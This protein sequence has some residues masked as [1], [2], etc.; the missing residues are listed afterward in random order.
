LILAVWQIHKHC[1]TLKYVKR[2]ILFTDAESDTDW[3][4][5]STLTQQLEKNNVTLIIM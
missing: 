4:D 2:M 5:L 1:R 3:Q